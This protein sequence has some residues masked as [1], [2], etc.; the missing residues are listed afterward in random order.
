[1]FNSEDRCVLKEHLGV[2][3]CPLSEIPTPHG[4]LIDADKEATLSTANNLVM[5]FLSED[6]AD[7]YNTGEAIKATLNY[8][9]E[10]E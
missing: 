9:S 7:G 4:R 6:E 1:M 2:S 8:V 3:D 10:E 5:E